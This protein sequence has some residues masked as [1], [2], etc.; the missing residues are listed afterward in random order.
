MTLP[1]SI[2]SEL[3]TKVTE[4]MKTVPN[5]SVSFSKSEVRCLYGSSIRVNVRFEMTVK[6]FITLFL[7]GQ[8]LCKFL[9]IN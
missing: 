9:M 8:R 1:S 6:G 7:I 2:G 5:Y 3:V 4:E